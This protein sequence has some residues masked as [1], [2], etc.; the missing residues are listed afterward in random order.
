MKRESKAFSVLSFDAQNHPYG[1]ILVE[2]ILLSKS[3]FMLLAIT[4][5]SLFSF[6]P[7]RCLVYHILNLSPSD[8]KVKAFSKDIKFIFSKK[9]KK[10]Q[11]VFLSV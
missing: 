6:L 8:I 3:R 4:E 2:D 11:V 10:K 7:I 5:N 9:V 1:I